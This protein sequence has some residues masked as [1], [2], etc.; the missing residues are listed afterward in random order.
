MIM[1]LR[2]LVQSREERLIYAALIIISANSGG[3]F[4]PIGDVTTIMLWIKGDRK[5]V[6]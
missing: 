4:S 6:V 1:V 3:A 5:S 2:K